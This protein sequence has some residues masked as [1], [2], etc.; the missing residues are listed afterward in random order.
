MESDKCEECLELIAANEKNV[1]S[2]N[3]TQYHFQCF[4]CEKCQQVVSLEFGDEIPVIVS[5]SGKPLCHGC[6][7]NCKKCGGKIIDDAVSVSDAETYHLRC[8]TCAK[9]ERVIDDLMFASIDERIVCLLCHTRSVN[10]TVNLDDITENNEALKMRLRV[11]EQRIRELEE[12]NAS[13]SAISKQTLSE[14]NELQIQHQKEISRRQDAEVA[15]SNLES[16]QN[17]IPH[18]SLSQTKEQ[19]VPKDIFDLKQLKKTLESDIQALASKK[20]QLISEI[21]HLNSDI[22]K[23]RA[24]EENPNKETKNSPSIHRLKTKSHLTH[25]SDKLSKFITK[26]P[27]EED[28]DHKTSIMDDISN[29]DSPKDAKK[30]NWKSMVEAQTTKLKQVTINNLNMSK[31]VISG[32]STGSPSP[33]KKNRLSLISKNGDF[34]GSE[35]KHTLQSHHYRM[36]KEC[37]ACHDRLWGKELR[38]E[39]CGYH[40]HIKCADN[41]GIC[42]E[43]LSASTDQL[44]PSETMFGSDLVKLYE[45]NGNNV[46][47]FIKKCAEIVEKRGMDYE[48]IYRKSGPLSQVHKIIA[49]ANKSEEEFEKLMQ[50]DSPDPDHQLLD[51]TAVTS[52]LKQFFRDLPES[53]VTTNDLYPAFMEAIRM[54]NMEDRILLIQTLIQKL[55]EAHVK[56]LQYILEH[57]TRVQ[58]YSKE[59]LMTA[60][61]LAVVFGPTLIKSTLNPETDMMDSQTKNNL[62]EFLILNA[63]QCI[64]LP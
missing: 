28:F 59:N 54:E 51:I 2:F 63:K 36:K 44:L 9:C 29:T 27:S 22:A 46:P 56:T 16:Q 41:A 24:A 25:S 32:L 3:D 26:P 55:P 62:M 50:E 45:Q 12:M 49:A 23:S 38:C 31:S 17:T 21:R 19:E 43:V 34:S 13:L 39:V 61:N 57:L 5:Q 20:V 40:C 60:S 7:A 18:P 11:A 58:S 1:I 52:A 30:T 4:K 48:G 10:S 6:A 53:L 14:Y 42:S 47:W 15:L 33:E 64:L 37:D 8:F 35:K